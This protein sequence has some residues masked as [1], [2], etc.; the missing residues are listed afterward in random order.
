MSS[1]VG[2]CFPGTSPRS[3]DYLALEA[4]L[5]LFGRAMPSAKD[6]RTAYIQEVF[7]A[8]QH[9]EHASVGQALARLLEQETSKEWESTSEK[10][11]ETL[12]KVYLAL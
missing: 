6:K 11:V 2:L 12:A 4:L 3:Q 8:S 5:T 1:T 9:S 7:L 10:V